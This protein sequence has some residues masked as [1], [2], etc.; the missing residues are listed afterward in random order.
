[1]KNLFKRSYEKLFNKKN[2]SSK[3]FTVAEIA[4]TLVVIGLVAS[5]SIAAMGNKAELINRHLYHGTFEKLNEIAK[6]VYERSSNKALPK[7]NSELCLEML[8]LVNKIGDASC[9][10]RTKTIFTDNK[11]AFTMSNGMKYYN[12]GVSEEAIEDCRTSAAP[13]RLIAN[14]DDFI[15]CVPSGGGAGITYKLISDIDMQ[16]KAYVAKSSFSGV[17]DGN[18]YSIK[19]VSATGGLFASTSNAT[20]KNLTLSGVNIT[21]AGNSGALV[22]TASGTTMNKVGVTSGNVVGRVAGGLAGSSSSSTM[23]NCFSTAS[24]SVSNAGG[25]ANGGGLIGYSSGTNITNSYAAGGVSTST[26]TTPPVIFLGG[27]IGKSSGGSISG[28]FWNNQSSGQVSTSGGGSGITTDKMNTASTF[29]AWD[30][31]IWNIQDGQAPLLKAFD[32]PS[33]YYS[34]FIDIDGKRKDSI[35]DEDIYKFDVFAVTN[36]IVPGLGSVAAEN[37]KLL[38]ASISYKDTDG[39][40]IWLKKDIGY[41]QALCLVGLVPQDHQYCVGKGVITTPKGGTI[42]S[43]AYTKDVLCTEAAECQINVNRP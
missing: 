2:T 35:L 13:T 36:L 3:A 10:L 7:T 30:T 12:Y 8:K 16:G 9:N 27:L 14:A 6:E 11:I 29:S 34:F 15:A 1:M 41:R 21:G 38:S 23:I 43:P 19:G 17:L 32:E 22:G 24:V 33:E 5:V 26:P 39:K 20:I 25:E 18:G 40:T 4:V 37:N 31:T 28:T 42:S